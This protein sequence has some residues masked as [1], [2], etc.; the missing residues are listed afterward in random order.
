M[1][2]ENDVVLGTAEDGSVYSVE[3]RKAMM[4]TMQSTYNTQ[5]YH[6]VGQAEQA[7]VNYVLEFRKRRVR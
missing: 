7:K 1:V 6:N 4:G 3:E 5:Y 2:L